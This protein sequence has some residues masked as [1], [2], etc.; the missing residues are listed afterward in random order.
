MSRKLDDAWNMMPWGKIG[1]VCKLIRYDARGHGESR[2]SYNPCDYTWENLVNDMLAI[3]DSLGV[4]RFIAGGASMGAAT[5]L[6]AAIKAPERVLGLILNIPPSAWEV[7][8]ARAEQLLQE[9]ELMES[10]GLENLIQM[11]RQA[12]IPKFF[13]DEPDLLSNANEELRSHDF[14]ALCAQQRG[15][16]LSN[17]PSR[18]IIASLKIPSLILA[19]QDDPLHPLS[20]AHELNHLLKG[21][22]LIVSENVYQARMQSLEVLNFIKG[23]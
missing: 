8:K 15:A 21:S 18:E 4:E 11:R 12:P 22:R 6:Y 13:K 1:L 3:A 17:L 16:A 20:M 2:A 19:R 9:T 10:K 23:L 7:R 14:K 5:A